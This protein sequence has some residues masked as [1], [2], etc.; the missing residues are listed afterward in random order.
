MEAQHSLSAP[1]PDLQAANDPA[2]PRL[3]PAPITPPL[4]RYIQER[5]GR[6]I[7]LR[8]RMMDLTLQDLAAA[9]GV[10][11]Q[12]VHK[13]ESGLCSVSAAQLW[14]IAQALEVPVSYFYETLATPEPWRA[15]A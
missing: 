4:T 3:R 8:R 5:L 9:C 7:R 12:Q 13:Y 15:E 2:T 1:A 6:A 11:F 10:T 14:G